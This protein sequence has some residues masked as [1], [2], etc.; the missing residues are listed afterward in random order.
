MPLVRIR[1]HLDA[2]LPPGKNKFPLLVFSH[3]M[4]SARFFYSALLQDLASHGYIVAAIDHSYWTIGEAFG[5]GAT[6]D[7]DHS[8][9]GRD[10]LSSDE[11]DRMMLEGIIVMAADQAFVTREL[12]DGEVPA[13]VA[14]ITDRI[15]STRIGVFGHSM[16]GMAAQ[17]ACLSSVYFRRCLS[18]DGAVWRPIH[19]GL[20]PAASQK[21]L[22]LLLSQQFFDPRADFAAAYTDL[23]QA[24]IVLLLK[25]SKH[26]SF[27]DFPLLESPGLQSS[28]PLQTHLRVR[29]VVREFFDAMSEDSVSVRL[30]DSLDSIE[31]ITVVD[32]KAI[33]T[34]KTL[35]RK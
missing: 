4:N 18:L 33:G 25:D 21:P 29:R 2:G 32:L 30:R 10:K 8:M 17:R 9:I 13:R 19:V 3:G 35:D 27:S 12:L 6:I 22:L 1:A 14:A 28:T 7:F 5:N 26:N 34:Q 11:I 20:Q 16:G 31:G 15:D 23:W 24:L